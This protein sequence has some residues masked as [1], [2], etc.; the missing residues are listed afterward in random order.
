MFAGPGDG[1]WGAWSAWS[2]CSSTCGNE[3]TVRTRS[4]DNPAPAH[5]GNECPQADAKSETKDC[6]LVACPGVV[7]DLYTVVLR[8]K[9]NVLFIN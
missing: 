4:R 6:G 7:I 1:E 2:E 3:T 9:C 5:N 8:H